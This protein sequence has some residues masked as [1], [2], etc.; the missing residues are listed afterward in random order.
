M[1][2]P[3]FK[4]RPIIERHQVAVRSSNYELYGDMSSRVMQTLMHLTSDVEIYSIDEAFCDLSG[5]LH[6]YPQK[7]IGRTFGVQ[8]IARKSEGT[9]SDRA[10]WPAAIASSRDTLATYLF[11]ILLRRSPGQAT[12]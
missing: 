7:I 3:F 6:R 12:P 4:V 5:F 11:P 2:V 9:V 8:N 10:S 1:G